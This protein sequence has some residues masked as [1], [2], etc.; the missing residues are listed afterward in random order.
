MSLAALNE[1]LR[2]DCDV[3]P[4]GSR[5]T[6]S[7]PPTDTDED[8]LVLVDG[9]D[10]LSK[11]VN[12]LHAAGFAWEGASEHYQDV[13]G[14]NFMSWRQGTT[15]Y[16]VTSSL[17]FARRHKAAT[18]LCKRL[19]LHDKSDRIALFRAVLYAEAP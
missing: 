10:S 18:S 1:F 6:C 15:N 12:L 9:G 14:T 5:V 3:T 19:N 7:P 11:L 17:S 2:T 4:C 16:I 8:F 13:A